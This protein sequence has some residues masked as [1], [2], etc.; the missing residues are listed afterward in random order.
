MRGS[1]PLEKKQLTLKTASITFVMNIAATF[2]FFFF[3]TL[4]LSPS[5]SLSGFLMP[6][7]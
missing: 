5:S 3:K 1:V 6:G 2:F 4:S 7:F